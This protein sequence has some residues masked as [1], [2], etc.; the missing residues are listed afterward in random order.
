MDYFQLMFHFI[1][2]VYEWFYI[3]VKL[4][5]VY[6]LFY[7][8]LNTSSF[9]PPLPPQKKKLIVNFCFILKKSCEKIWFESKLPYTYKSSWLSMFSYVNQLLFV[10][11]LFPTTYFCKKDVD[12]L[13]ILILIRTFD[14]S[15]VEKYSWWWGYRNPH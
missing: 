13:K 8:I 4:W 5:R 11:T 12:N 10:T 15:F 14:G 2:K 3:V 6:M 7:W 1:S 9:P